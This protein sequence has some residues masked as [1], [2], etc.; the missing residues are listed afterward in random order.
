MQEGEDGLWV[1]VVVNHG[2]CHGADQRSKDSGQLLGHSARVC[3]ET[4]DGGV[5]AESAPPSCSME[6]STAFSLSSCCEKPIILLRSDK[7]K[8]MNQ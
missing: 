8:I 7:I 4:A 1:E 6:L 5:D 3:V 2:F